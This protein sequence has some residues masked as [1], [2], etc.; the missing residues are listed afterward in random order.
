MVIAMTSGLAA[1]TT[2]YDLRPLPPTPENLALAVRDKDVVKLHPG[3]ITIC[4]Q[5]AY[6][7]GPYT[8][9]TAEKDADKARIVDR[10]WDAM[11]A[12]PRLVGGRLCG[13]EEIRTN[14]LG[15]TASARCLAPSEISAVMIPTSHPIVEG[16][17]IERWV[18]S[19]PGSPPA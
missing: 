4:L 10:R 2:G 8:S 3:K 12:D 1:C 13:V 11:I 15:D 17:V 5:Q 14:G 18:S 9:V 7:I 19:C 6:P 16:S